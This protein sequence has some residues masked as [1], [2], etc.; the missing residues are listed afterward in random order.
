MIPEVHSTV[1]L[2]EEE[3]RRVERPFVW[4][5]ALAVAFLA[6]LPAL[7][8]LL[9][10]PAGS[11]YLGYQ[12][13]TD[14][15]MVYAAWMRQAMDGR[16]LMDNR[17]TTEAQP[18]LTI[19]LYFFVLGLV[20]KV[21]GIALASTLARVGFSVLFVHLLYRLLRKLEWSVYTTKLALALAIFGGGLGF[22]VWHTYGRLIVRTAPEVLKSLML[23][24]L[25]TDVW[26][27]EGFVFPSMLTNGLFMVSLCLIL[28]AFNA[29]LEARD[30][31]KP[32]LPGALAMG[33]LM[34][35]HSY[36]VLLIALSMLGFLVMSARRRQVSGPW[37]AR[38]MVVGLGVVPA[39][40]WFVYVLKNDPVFQAR[41][42]TETYTSNFRTVFFGYAPLMFLALLGI[43]ARDGAHIRSR[44]VGAGLVAALLAGLFVLAAGHQEKYFL[45]MPLWAASF[46]VAL[47]ALFFLADERPGWNLLVSWAVIGAVAIYFPALFQRKLA[48]G[49]SIPWAVLAAEGV[50]EVFKNRERSARNL[51]T[52][53]A[54]LLVSGSSGRWLLREF[55]LIQ[56]NVSTTTVHPVYLTSDVR[57]ILAY[58]DEQKGRH[59]LIAPPGVP[60]RPV[61]TQTREPIVDEFATPIIPDLNSIASGLTGIYTYAGHWSETPNYDARRAELTSLYFKADFPDAKRARLKELGVDYMIVPIPEAFPEASFPDLRNLGEVVV[62]GDQFSLLHIP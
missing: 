3:R 58:L 2:T 15:H 20:A 32:V 22:L 10:T 11:A 45:D 31:W 1:E 39:A 41:A 19:H 40:L 12:F 29:F 23:G 61:D 47:V 37:V 6:V 35:I 24:Q 27:P 50:W 17:F 36:D 60:S 52:V 55:S 44:R 46:A 13:N 33:A 42:A 43:A 16:L 34:N 51:A 59:V 7:V 53:L 49:L 9:R 28:V 48:M 57:K 62:D 18:G 30:S 38:A 26:Q 56:E 5:L 25:P 4:L 21:T 8:G 14:D 54:I